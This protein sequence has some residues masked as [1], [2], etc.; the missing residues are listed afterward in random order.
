MKQFSKL[1]YK[2]EMDQLS[3]YSLKD[4]LLQNSL[5]SK[6]PQYSSRLFNDSSSNNVNSINYRGKSYE[7]LNRNQDYIN[8][9]ISINKQ[10]GNLIP[11]STINRASSQKISPIYNTT[12]IDFKK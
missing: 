2:T 3:N 5:Q 9:E 12:S 4:T 7:T 6:K 11:N 10:N 1:N 8:T